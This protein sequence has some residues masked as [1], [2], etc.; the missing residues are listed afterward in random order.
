MSS[1]LRFVL[2]FA[3]TSTTFRPLPL[4]SFLSLGQACR[5]GTYSCPSSP[6]SKATPSTEKTLSE[7][8]G[9]D[10]S[11]DLDIEPPLGWAWS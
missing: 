8:I 11:G 1:S 2:D 3:L 7:K 9:R 4:R 6:F 5:R 10:R